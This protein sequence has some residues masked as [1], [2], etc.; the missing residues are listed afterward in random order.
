MA[1]RNLPVRI[2]RFLL[3]LIAILFLLSIFWVVILKWV[4]VWV[5]PLMVQQSIIHAGDKDY[6]TRS[7]WRSLDKISPEMAKA[8]I[9]SEDQRFLDHDGF[10]RE[11][12]RNALEER[13][14]GTRIRGASTISQ[15]T[16]K[17]VFCWPS[18]T[19]LRKGVE[20]YFTLLIEIIWGKK[21][22]LEVYLNV[23]E[24]GTGIYG[25]EAAAQAHFEH[26]A[27]KLSRREACLIAACLPE[28]RKRNAG[29]PSNYVSRRAGEIS[30]QIGNLAFPDW[31][32][33]K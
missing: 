29:K 1:P 19:W 30:R 18:R 32:T 15:Q 33:G 12:I 3:R 31:I 13:R 23:A 17:N 27:D 26:G 8:V 6:H 28:P 5:T 14:K 25:A 16:A 2:L 7:T 9:A 20:A 22:I 24:M 11:E 4:P 10:D 21:R